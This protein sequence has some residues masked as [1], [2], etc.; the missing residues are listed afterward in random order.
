[1][2]ALA[3]FGLAHDHFAPHPETNAAFYSGTNLGGILRLH[4]QL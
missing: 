2:N 3:D 4:I 1:L